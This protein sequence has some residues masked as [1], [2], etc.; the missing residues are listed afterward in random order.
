[1]LGT[2]EPAPAFELL[3]LDGEHQRLGDALT[4]GPAL[5]AFWKPD[6]AT[7]HLAFPYLQRL[8]DVYP[9][10]GW[11]LLAVSQESATASAAFARRYGAMFPVLIDGIGWPVSQLYDPEATPTFFLI[12]PNG[13][14]EMT[15]VGFDKVELN[16]IAG[17]LAGYL[18][19]PAEEFATENDD[20]PPFQPG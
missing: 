5:V 2:G 15:S 8:V 4:V 1:M 9:S 18:G 17:R 6:C 16:E 19:E 3:D 14:I 7:C 20:N 13:T 12:A 11:R 10:G